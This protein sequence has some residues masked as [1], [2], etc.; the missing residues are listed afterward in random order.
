M[1]AFKCV[2]KTLLAEFD[3]LKPYMSASGR[4]CE[5]SLLATSF[6]ELDGVTRTITPRLV[7]LLSSLSTTKD[8]RRRNV[9]KKSNRV[10]V[11]ERLFDYSVD[12]W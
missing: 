3:T 4:T 1:F 8:Q 6:K 11:L 12:N 7:G 5:K 9:T 10:C 2:Q